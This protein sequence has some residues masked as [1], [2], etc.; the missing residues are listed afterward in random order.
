MTD[1]ADLVARNAEFAAHHFAPD[2]TINPSGNMMVVG[3]V[4]P[5][6][7]P[8]RVL[9][10]GHGEAAVIRNVGGR[11]VDQPGDQEVRGVQHGGD[12]L[13][14]GPDRAAGVEDVLVSQLVLG[15]LEVLGEQVRKR[16]DVGHAAVRVVEDDEVPGAR[17]VGRGVGLPDLAEHG[18]VR[19]VAGV[20][21]TPAW[22]NSSS[23]RPPWA[24]PDDH[25]PR[26]TETRLR[27]DGPVNRVAVHQSVRSS[28]DPLAGVAAA[29]AAGVDS[30]GLH[31]AS[32]AAVETLWDKGAGSALL[33]TLVDALLVSRVTA[34]DVGRVD[35]AVP[36]DPTDVGS[37]KYRVLDLGSR[38]G[39]QFV[40]V[41]ATE[42]GVEENRG[43]SR[44]WTTRRPDGRCVRCWCR[45]PGP[46]PPGSARPRRSCGARGAGWSSTCGPGPRTR[47]R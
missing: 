6:V 44:S 13:H 8:T 12:R 32:I 34:L 33:A 41:H 19:N 9:G 30:I 2:L 16:R 45:S 14:V 20:M 35:L 18:Q 7:D 23:P 31:V 22:W 42:G 10:I 37:P 5:R 15:D 1:T 27:E 40:T 36:G 26:G 28:P 4:D 39:C 43:G 24:R 11:V 47:T 3:C 38:L 17:P 21:S 46:P 29:R 25:G